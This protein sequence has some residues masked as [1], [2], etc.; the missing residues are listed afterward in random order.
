M[1][2]VE[3]RTEILV[4][5]GESSKR[6]DHFLAN[7]DPDFS[8]TILQRLILDGQITIDG[9]TVKPSHKIKP[10]DR[11]ILIVPRPEPLDIQPEPIPLEILYEDDSLLV[12]NKQA[13]LVVHPA[14]GNWSGTLV[15]A[16]LYHLQTETGSLSNIGGKERPGLVHRLDKNTTGVMVVAKHDQ[17][18]ANLASQFKRHSITRVYEALI[19]GVPK[20]HEGTI[21]L[22]IGRDTKERKKFSANT[23]RPKA[24][25]TVYRVTERFGRIASTVDLFPQTGRTHQLRV[26]L[27]SISCPILGDPTYGGKRVSSLEDIHI[28][29]VMLHA[30]VLGFV[31]PMTQ[32]EM[33][34]S[35]PMP[36]DM[37]ETIQLIRTRISPVTTQQREGKKS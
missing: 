8:R 28:P 20:K 25:A 16:L 35:A 19:L 4:T 9:Q 2:H 27:A 5:A 11:I 34:F 24:S 30:K 29:R 13:D 7:H 15:N 36:V 21:E 18:H 10:G 23:A 12:L 14:P 31:H 33:I 37:K 32:E 26:H 1:P 17:A 6:L 22:A 3:T